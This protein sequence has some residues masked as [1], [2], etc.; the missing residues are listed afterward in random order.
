MNEEIIHRLEHLEQR[1]NLLQASVDSLAITVCQLLVGQ[2]LQPKAEVSPPLSEEQRRELLRM[3]LDA[4][5]TNRDR[6]S[7]KLSE[8]PFLPPDRPKT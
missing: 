6:T 7:S 2:S 8:F 5:K 3:H 4:Y 1:I